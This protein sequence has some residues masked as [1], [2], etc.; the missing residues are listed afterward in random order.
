M[1]R[2]K[3]EQLL[4]IV[5]GDIDR[6]VYPDGEALPSERQLA[7]QYEVSRVSVRTVMEQLVGKGRVYKV[8]G[9]GNFVGH[10]M[11]TASKGRSRSYMIAYTALGHAQSPHVSAIAT[12]IR[13]T[14]EA[15]GYHLI[16]TG[17]S[18]QLEAEK[19]VA[20][21][22]IL[23]NIDGLVLTPAMEG[24]QNNR[25][26][27]AELSRQGVPFVLV[28][29]LVSSQNWTSIGLDSTSGICEGMQRLVRAGHRNIAYIGP[30]HYPIAESRFD[31]YRKG[32]RELGLAFD[33]RLVFDDN[34]SGD[35]PFDPF[36][37]GEHGAE[38]LHSRPVQFT[39]FVCFSD[40]VAYGAWTRLMALG[41]KPGDR[42]CIVGFD[43]LPIAHDDFR[44]H[45]ITFIS[46]EQQIGQLAA[47]CL[48]EQIERPA[49][50]SG[51]TILLP[52]SL[53]LPDP[54]PLAMTPQ[55]IE[56]VADNWLATIGV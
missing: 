43:N 56:N 39:A 2:F 52:P 25:A 47:S 36:A 40:V 34:P 45:L 21:Q 37:Y 13:Q 31:A 1:P 50:T 48:I 9:R 6:G 14:I 16:I 3:Y 29:R 17:F 49:R 15:R 38:Q 20:H 53:C 54:A 33:P 27:Y 28:D 44:S 10:A 41:W 35:A 12:A 4:K 18:G 11:S 46:P 24:M 23:K 22:L 26:F 8:P 42:R 7:E 51:R 55:I 5:E 19:R 32:L 30:T